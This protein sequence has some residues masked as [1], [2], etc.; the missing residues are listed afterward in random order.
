MK[1]IKNWKKISLK[2]I[3]RLINQLELDKSGLFFQTHSG[4]RRSIVSQPTIF[5]SNPFNHIRVEQ[6]LSKIQSMST[7]T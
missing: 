5:C 2:S 7:F 3:Y 6:S 4:W 1:R